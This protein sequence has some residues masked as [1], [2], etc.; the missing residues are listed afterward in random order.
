M[1]STWQL[2]FDQIQRQ[3]KLSAR[4]LR[5][6]TYFDNKDL[7]IVV[8]SSAVLAQRAKI[9]SHYHRAQQLQRNKLRRLAK[10]LPKDKTRLQGPQLH[11]NKAELL[12]KLQSKKVIHTKRSSSQAPT[13]P[14]LL[15]PLDRQSTTVQD[16]LFHLAETIGISEI[17][18][19]MDRSMWNLCQDE[20]NCDWTHSGS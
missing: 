8:L 4:L 16:S 1:H 7:C 15:R 6:W 20:G 18:M 17:E 19:G 10:Q 2:S 13:D 3:N 12:A 14:R 11:R 5:W 9:V